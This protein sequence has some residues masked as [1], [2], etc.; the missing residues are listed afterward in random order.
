MTDP[1]PQN[2]IVSRF[3]LRER[4]ST[5]GPGAVSRYA[6][7]TLRAGRVW[8]PL[9][10]LK[11]LLRVA[12]PDAEISWGVEVL[13][14]LTGLGLDNLLVVDG[15]A[16][17]ELERVLEAVGLRHVASEDGGAVAVEMARPR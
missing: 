6:P 11:E 4:T 16:V 7:E 1:A 10:I 9:Q 15:P 13:E 12:Y 3:N 17:G 2:Y 14:H 5:R 8:T